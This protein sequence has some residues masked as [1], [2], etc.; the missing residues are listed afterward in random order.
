MTEKDYLWLN[1][2]DLPYFRAMLR[3]VEARFY[4]DFELSPPTLDVGCGDGHFAS[5]AFDRPLE[6]GLDPWGGPIRQAA[7]LGGYCSLIQ[8]DGGQMPFPDGYFASAVSNS[9]LEHIPRVEQVLA[10]TARVLHPEGLFLFSV[11]NPGYFSE[12]SIPSWFRRMRLSSFGDRYTQWFQHMSRVEHAVGPEVWQVWL[13][14]AGFRLDKFWHYFS[15]QAMRVLEWGHFFGA[16]TLL[17][18]S[19]TGRWILVPKPWNLFLTDRLV[20]GY[21]QAVPDPRG[22]FTFYVARKI[23]T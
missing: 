18:H 15:P 4:Q 19:L 7:Q 20:R 12:L 3:A 17:P 5:I 11:P 21:A 13:E 9:V 2:R 10:E 8:A 1:L 23:N 6:V 14:R 16:P 22:T